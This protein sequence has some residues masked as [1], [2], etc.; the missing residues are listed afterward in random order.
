[1][2]HSCKAMQLQDQEQGLTP[3]VAAT[4]VMMLM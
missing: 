4:A 1:M 3:D 2:S